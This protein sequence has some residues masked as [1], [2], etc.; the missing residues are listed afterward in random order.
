M[1]E[2]IKIIIKHYRMGK[3]WKIIVPKMSGIMIF[4]L[5]FFREIGDKIW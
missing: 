4:Q 3:G 2:Q 1:K 5:Y